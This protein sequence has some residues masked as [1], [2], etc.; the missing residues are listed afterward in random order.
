MRRRTLWWAWYPQ[1]RECC[2][3]GAGVLPRVRDSPDVYVGGGDGPDPGHGPTFWFFPP[4]C[5]G[6]G[7]DSLLF[8]GLLTLRFGLCA[9]L[10]ARGLGGLRTFVLHRVK[11]TTYSPRIVASPLG[12]TL[13]GF[14]TPLLFRFLEFLRVVAF[15]VA[16]I[17]IMRTVS[18]SRSTG[19]IALAISL[20]WL[21]TT[22]IRVESGGL[23][24]S[25]GHSPLLVVTEQSSALFLRVRRVRPWFQAINSLTT[26]SSRSLSSTGSKEASAI[27][28]IL[29]HSGTAW[30]DNITQEH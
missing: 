10:P 3:L 25:S 5:A 13:T 15:C 6:V 11:L 2:G 7:W 29:P 17:L 23:L 22:A 26:T 1:V 14:F 4:P 30:S 12:F 19:G 18:T 21:S 24:C 27:D 16:F 20:R 28:Q 8:N 9:P